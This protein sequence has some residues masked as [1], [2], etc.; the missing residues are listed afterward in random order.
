MDGVLADFQNRKQEWCE[1][2][3]LTPPVN[4]SYSDMTEKEKEDVKKFWESL[5]ISYW[6][7]MKPIEYKETY[8]WLSELSLKH[9]LGIISNVTRTGWETATQG[10]A[11]WLTKHFPGIFAEIHITIFDKSNYAE[12]NVLVDD[13]PSNIASWEQAGGYGILYKNLNQAKLDLM[14]KLEDIRKQKEDIIC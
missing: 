3:K 2:Y 9:K 8:H 12:G 13:R 6:T 1:Q 4:I 5:T 10:K 7:E 11:V 14:L